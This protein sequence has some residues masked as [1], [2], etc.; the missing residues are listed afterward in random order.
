MCGIAGFLAL[1][2]RRRE[3]PAPETLDRMTDTLTHRGPDSRGTWHDAGHGVGLGHRR[4]AIRDLSP[5][6]HQPMTSTCGRYVI[7]Y[8]GEIYSHQEIARD[9][10]RTGRPLHGTSDTVVLLEA[11]AEWGVEAVVPRLIGMFAFAFFDKQTGELV[12]VRDRLGIKPVYWGLVEGLLIFGSE[13]KAL[14]AIPD[15]P[16][17]I[18]RN[19]LAAYMRHNYIPAPHSIYQGIHKLEPGT[20]LR[21]GRDG[22]PKITRYWNLR[23]IVEH[24]VRSLSTASDEE[25]LAEL[26]TLLADAVRRRMVADVPLGTLL[27][28]GIDSSLVTAL[29]AEASD[30]P[31]NTF[32]IGFH[33]QGF[34]EAPFARKIARHLGTDHT[35]LYVEPGHALELVG[36]LPFWYDEPFADS[37][38]IPTALVCE[39]TRRHVTV[40]LSGDGGDELFAGYTRY[41]FGMN[42]W[43]KISLAPYGL[44]RFLAHR[45][46]EQSTARLDGLGGLLC[47][48]Y[49]HNRFGEQVHRL[50]HAILLKDPDLMY[51]QMLS[52]WHEPEALV[53]DAVEAKGI[54]WDSSVI[55][56][57]PD[58]LDRMQFL[59]TVTYLPDDILTKIDRASMCVA[60]EARVPL[61][62]HRVVE[63][64]WSLPQRLKL[65]NGQSKWALRQL[66]YRRVPRTLIDRPKMGFGVPIGDWLRGP[67]RDWAEHLLD[68]TRLEH[69]GLFAPQPIRACWAAHLGGTDW[70]YPLWDVLMAQAWIE[71]NPGIDTRAL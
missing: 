39:L 62:D 52:H 44:R 51:R 64:A 59:D 67:L 50:A 66:L 47:R 7:V 60:L 13:L 58:F 19:A 33:E 2:T 4:L 65:R 20:L 37:S 36:K 41:T 43:K 10:E 55:R 54:L 5:S 6:G 31:I 15:W 68:R 26:D 8:N 71:A 34:D 61:L 18:D 32:S 25:L 3:L 24:A 30:R 14:R 40:V 17:R 38:Q 53:L 16:A 22:V 70:T 63:K 12:L 9:L 42:L 69:Q 27:S 29:M 11:C 1:D 23:T 21:V 57:V 56:S 35:E 49:R 28:G 46:L 45:I 48:R